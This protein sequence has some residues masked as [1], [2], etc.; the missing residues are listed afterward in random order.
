MIKI[1]RITVTRFVLAC[2]ICTMLIVSTAQEPDFEISKSYIEE[3]IIDIMSVGGTTHDYVDS[4]MSDNDSSADVG[5]ETS[6]VN[7]QD[8][9]PD[10]DYM[11]IQENDM[12]GAGVDEW[13][14]NDGDATVLAKATHHGSSIYLESVD[15]SNF[16]TIDYGTGY[17]QWYTF[18]NTVGDA[19]TYTVNISVYF[20]S[21]DGNDDLEWQ[22]DTNGDDTY[23]YMGTIDN[24]TSGWYT[25]SVGSLSQADVNSARVKLIGIASAGYNDPDID[26]VRLGVYKAGGSTNYQIDFEYNWSNADFDEVT[27]TLCFYTANSPAGEDLN[28]SYWNITGTDHWTKL[29][30]ITGDGWNNMT[31]INLNSSYYTIRLNGT[32]EITDTTQ[33]DWDIDVIKLYTTEVEWWDTDWLYSKSISLTNAVNDYQMFINV[34]KPLDGGDV[35]CSGNCED[36]FGDIRF[37]DIDNVTELDYWMEK[38]VSGE[39]AWYWIELPSDVE[40][41]NAIYIYYGKSKEEYTGD[42]DDVFFYFEDWTTDNT[43]EWDYTYVDANYQVYALSDTYLPQDDVARNRRWRWSANLSHWDAHL[44]GTGLWFHQQDVNDNYNQLDGAGLTT[45]TDTDAGASDTTFGGKPNLKTGGSSSGTYSWFPINSDAENFCIYEILVGDGTTQ[46]NVKLWKNNSYR[47]IQLFN[48]WNNNTMPVSSKMNYTAIVLGSYGGSLN[49]VFQHSDNDYL[50]VYCSRVAGSEVGYFIDYMFYSL[51][52]PTEPSISSVSD[53]Q[54]QSGVN[55]PPVNSVPIPAHEAT[56]VSVSMTQFNITINDPNGNGMNITWLTN[57]SGSWETM[58]TNSSGGGLSNGTY[59]CLNTSGIVAEN[60]K[61]WWNVSTEDGNGGWDNDTYFFTTYAN[62]APTISNVYPVNN[63]YGSAGFTPTLYIDVDDTEGDTINITWQ[64]YN[65]SS[66]NTFGTNLTE[67]CNDTYY[68]PFDNATEYHRNYTWRV[69]VNDSSGNWVNRS[70]EFVADIIFI[71]DPNNPVLESGDGDLC[72]SP[73]IVYNAQNDSWHLFY[74]Y[75]EDGLAP[76]DIYRCDLTDVNQSSISYP[77]TLVLEDGTYRFWIAKVLKYIENSTAVYEGGKYWMYFSDAGTGQTQDIYYA[78]ADYLDGDW[79]INPTAIINNTDQAWHNTFCGRLGLTAKKDTD[80]NYILMYDGQ[81]SD[82]EDS[83]GYATS[84][85]KTSWTEYAGNPVMSP[86]HTATGGEP[87]DQPWDD[88]WLEYPFL[89]KRP[90]NDN[91]YIIYDGLFRN[92][93]GNTWSAERLGYANSSDMNTWTR[94]DWN[95]IFNE[96]HPEFSEIWD[97]NDTS[98]PT[99]AISANGTT[100]YLFY[101]GEESEVTNYYSIGRAWSNNFDDVFPLGENNAPTLTSDSVSPSTG[102]ASYTVFYFNVTWTDADNDNPTDS[103][104]YLK[105]NISRSGWDTNQTMIWVSGANDTGALYSYNT[106]LTAGSYTYYMW[107]CDGNGGY[108][109]ATAVEPSV[110]AQSLSFTVTKSSPSSDQFDFKDWSPIGMSNYNVSEDNQT[111]VLSAVNITNTGNVPL[112]FSINW[113]ASPGAGVSMKWG[114]VFASPPNPGVNILL[115]SPAEEWFISNLA[116]T[117]YIEIFLWMDFVSVGAGSG[118]QDVTI[119]SYIYEG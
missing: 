3:K 33:D 76:R 23:E 55:L 54:Q 101:E 95:P 72:T 26:A 75:K 13:L 105:V 69:L 27:E 86:G 7:A 116:P 94:Y 91:Y 99:L 102:V 2:I 9:S 77:G 108:D 85:T 15:A 47:D 14:E 104:A 92:T 45:Y 98:D 71:K 114:E 52:N 50:E 37:I 58:Q 113:I 56:Q 103:G 84:T 96:S 117:D 42:G 118:S 82:T 10:S 112:N 78:T 29:G 38:N 60:T 22:V 53:E 81:D 24:P 28:V 19:G 68:Q 18:D 110:S 61:Y 83:L 66:W 67:A 39:H 73:D 100:T 16:L 93:T 109:D 115:V 88:D 64:W 25:D 80:G 111:A 90:G 17:A 12:G 21:G 8:T 107:A 63:S 34:S 30:T 87:P 48:L 6:F 74:T 40:T 106:Q 32:A 70:Y 62:Q 119:T 44:T 1:N 11:N 97:N 65:D 49:N 57:W 43:G 59:Y 51:Y 4:N 36:D 41:D 79:T 46:L 31:A 20:I 89:F 5:I 35:N